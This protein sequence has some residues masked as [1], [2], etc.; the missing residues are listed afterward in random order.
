M[1]GIRRKPLFFRTSKTS[2]NLDL[3]SPFRLSFLARKWT[4]K[5]IQRK[6]NI[7]G[8]IAA[9]AIS[10]YGL[11]SISA[12]TNAVDAITGGKK[13][14]PKEAAASTAPANVDLYPDFFIKGIVNAPV[15]TT[16]AIALPLIVPISALP[17]TATLAGPPEYLPSMAIA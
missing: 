12:I 11:P 5:I 2:G 13:Y 1:T 16:F 7:A 6:Y 10:K 3:G 9:T 17:T 8:I 15:V 4:F 14:P